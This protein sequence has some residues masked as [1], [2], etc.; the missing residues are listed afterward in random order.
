MLSINVIMNSSIVRRLKFGGYPNLTLP[1]G[2]A[3]LGSRCRLMHAAAEVERSTQFGHRISRGIHRHV[4]QARRVMDQC[5][6]WRKP[7]PK[8]DPRGM[9][10]QMSPVDIT[11]SGPDHLVLIFPA[12]SRFGAE[13][14]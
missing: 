10:S 1:G 11:Q 2:K 8:G 5:R 3:G 14:A 7:P 4:A 13:V 9:R 12:S 6:A